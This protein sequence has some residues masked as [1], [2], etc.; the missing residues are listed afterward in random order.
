LE[1][2]RD[3]DDAVGFKRDTGL[4]L[5]GTEGFLQARVVAGAGLHLD[6]GHR[7]PELGEIVGGWMICT[8]LRQSPFGAAH[9]LVERNTFLPVPLD[10][11]LLRIDQL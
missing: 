7:L 4:P 10:G 2:R 1:Y 3:R 6:F 8:P 9:F 5:K 11:G